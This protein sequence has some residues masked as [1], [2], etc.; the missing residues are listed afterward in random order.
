[1]PSRRIHR[2]VPYRPEIGA[3]RNT[4]HLRETQVSAVEAAVAAKTGLAVPFDYESKSVQTEHEIEHED[5]N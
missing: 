5:A 3:F 2:R 1:V 4:L